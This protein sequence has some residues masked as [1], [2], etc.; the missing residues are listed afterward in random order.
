MAVCR[1]SFIAVSESQRVRT[2][3]SLLFIKEIVLCAK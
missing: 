2:I 1:I 3:V